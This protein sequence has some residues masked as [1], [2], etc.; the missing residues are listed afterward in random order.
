VLHAGQAPDPIARWPENQDGQEGPTA[1]GLHPGRGRPLAYLVTHPPYGSGSSE[2]VPHS[3]CACESSVRL[4]DRALWASHRSCDIR[5][6]IVTGCPNSSVCTHGACPDVDSLEIDIAQSHSC[7]AQ[8][9][10]R[11]AQFV[12]WPPRIRLFNQ[13]RLV[14]KGCTPE[15][16]RSTYRSLIR[17]TTRKQGRQ[18]DKREGCCT[19]HRNGPQDRVICI[20]VIVVLMI[21]VI[22]MCG[23]DSSALVSVMTAVAVMLRASIARP[24]PRAVV[25]AS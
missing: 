16:R 11:V 5:S 15:I 10:S 2:A 18:M 4:G 12:C 21:V 17:P 22:R 9:H 20:V 1:V 24:S 13:L 23:F 19:P 7:V 8:S 3:R 25:T 6:P 14:G